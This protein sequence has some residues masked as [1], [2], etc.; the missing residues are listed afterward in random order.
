MSAKESGIRLQRLRSRTKQHL[1]LEE[2]SRKFAGLRD[3]GSLAQTTLKNRVKN[4]SSIN[5]F[6][7]N[8]VSPYQSQKP[9]RVLQLRNA[10]NLQSTADSRKLQANHS[11]KHKNR[12]SHTKPSLPLPSSTKQSMTTDDL[13]IYSAKIELQ[14]RQLSPLLISPTNLPSP[15]GICTLQCRPSQQAKM[16]EKQKRKSKLTTA[17]PTVDHYINNIQDDITMKD[18]ILPHISTQQTEYKP[19]INTPTIHTSTDKSTLVIPQ[20]TIRSATPTIQPGLIVPDII[21]R[22]ATPLPEMNLV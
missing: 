10:V 20:I 17:T 2:A 16:K 8:S 12:S 19:S 22:L 4:L 9:L 5:V 14:R 3:Y 13:S 1:S 18:K 21:I 6:T 15:Y 11:I 7:D